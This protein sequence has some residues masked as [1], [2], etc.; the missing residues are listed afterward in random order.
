MRFRILSFLFC[1]VYILCSIR[2]ACAAT[3]ISISSR[4][5]GVF[6]LQGAGLE[7]MGGM[8]ITIGYDVSSLTNPRVVQG[9]LVSGGMMIAN[10]NAPGSVRIAMVQPKG[11]SGAGSIATISFD[12]SGVTPGKILSLNANLVDTKGAK[13]A[14]QSQVFN[15]AETTFPLFQTTSDTTSGASSAQTANTSAQSV[16]TGQSA[17]NSGATPAWLGTVT[18]PFDTASPS[19]EKARQEPS[20]QQIPSQPE[21]RPVETAKNPDTETQ[22]KFIEPPPADTKRKAVIHK[23]VLKHFQNYRGE[24]TLQAFTALFKQSAI[25]GIRQEPPIAL[26]DGKSSI[27][28]FIESAPVGN[29]TPNFVLKGAKLVSLKMDG[30]NSYLLEI[31]PEPKVY[32]ATV[33]VLR[34]DTLNEF[35]LTI[36][37]PLVMKTGDIEILSEENFKAF[38][39]RSGTEK[40]FRPDL[41]GDGVWNYIDEYVLTANYFT[42]NPSKAVDV[43]K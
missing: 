11:I 2:F 13:I 41:N 3:T 29:E 30:D 27:R 33:T 42:R 37:P 8:D 20:P 32:E 22:S 39:K 16:Q 14:S 34:N 38:L 23:S 28:L 25:P 31:I 5:G 1:F 36:A 26:S 24:R 43:K 40:A 21:Q 10:T 35:P 17:V 18:M 4:G 12:L 7:G 15:S 19:N 9:G 6:E